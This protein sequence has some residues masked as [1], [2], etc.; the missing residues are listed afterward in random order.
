M[1]A[2]TAFNK[3]C[4]IPGATVAMVSF[5]PEGI[6]IGL[7]RRFRRLACPCGF[8]TRASYDSSVRRWRHLTSEPAGC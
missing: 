2:T 5:T 1:R 7:R 4:E 6:V 8:T 3:M